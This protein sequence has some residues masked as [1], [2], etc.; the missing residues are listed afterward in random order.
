MKFHMPFS[1]GPLVMAIKLNTKMFCRATSFLPHFEKFYSNKL[2]YFSQVNHTIFRTPEQVVIMLL[3]IHV[4]MMLLLLTVGNYKVW[5][6][7]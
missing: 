5:G 6:W 7:G 3:H 2:A 1:K 4:S